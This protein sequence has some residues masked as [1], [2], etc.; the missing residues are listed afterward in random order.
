M[1]R[2]WRENFSLEG[3]GRRRREENSDDQTHTTSNSAVAA[4]HPDETRIKTC[5]GWKRA[6][7]G[8]GVRGTVEQR[9]ASSRRLVPVSITRH[10]PRIGERRKFPEWLHTRT[11]SGGQKRNAL[12]WILHWFPRRGRVT[13]TQPFILDKSRGETQRE[14]EVVEL[15]ETLRIIEREANTRRNQSTEDFRGNRIVQQ[16]N[17]ATEGVVWYQNKQIRDE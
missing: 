5:G 7:R 1:L 16:N 15:L 12:R 11:P 3:R 8:G 9:R 13:R 4:V 14:E 6:G 10:P 2:K 17:Q